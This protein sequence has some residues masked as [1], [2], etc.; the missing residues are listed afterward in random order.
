MPQWSVVFCYPNPILNSAKLYPCLL[1]SERKVSPSPHVQSPH[2]SGWGRHSQN[3]TTILR[4]GHPFSD[5]I[6]IRFLD[7]KFPAQISSVLEGHQRVTYTGTISQFNKNSFLS[8]LS[9]DL[10]PP[11]YTGGCQR[12]LTI[13][14]KPVTCTLLGG[15]GHVT[16]AP[17]LS[18]RQFP[19][20]QKHTE[21][22]VERTRCRY[23]MHH[24]QKASC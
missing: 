20:S 24:Q 19:I 22:C 23:I 3:M 21:G 1:P 4:T 8:A 18:H 5:F 15:K 11:D 6:K 10:P 13:R 7:T 16:C 17:H 2:Q 9:S 14:K 12:F